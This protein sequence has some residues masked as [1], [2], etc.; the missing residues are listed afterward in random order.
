MSENEHDFLGLFPPG[1]TPDDVLDAFPEEATLDDV[2][3]AL[4]DERVRAGLL[5]AVAELKR[6]WMRLEAKIHTNVQEHGF[7]VMLV[8]DH[9][10]RKPHFAYTI[11]LHHTNPA[12]CEIFMIG[13]N[14]AQLRR[15]V[16]DIARRMLAGGRYEAGKPNADFTAN[17]L[18]FF[19][20]EID[21]QHYN[22]YLGWAIRYYARQ[23]FPV[24]QVVWCDTRGKFPWQEGFEEPFRA[25]QPVLFDPAPYTTPPPDAS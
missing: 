17:G 25:Q 11:G 19:F 23:H 20:G 3:A 8:F 10:G 24:Q 13:L 7:F 6:R 18:P 15:I 9:T 2:R 1:T 16:P 22:G 14:L 4:A 21:P 12:L 5:D